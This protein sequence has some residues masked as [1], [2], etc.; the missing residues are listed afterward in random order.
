[1]RPLHRQLPGR[2]GNVLAQSQW[3]TGLLT[4]DAFAGRM[5]ISSVVLCTVM[6]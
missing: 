6:P 3:P 5:R 2:E 1:M 4:G